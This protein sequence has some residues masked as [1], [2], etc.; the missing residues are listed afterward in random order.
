MH[1]HML[2]VLISRNKIHPK[3]NKT[4]AGD[5]NNGSDCARRNFRPMHVKAGTE[6]WDEKLSCLGP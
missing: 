2:I 3:A 6:L 5:Y 1:L 4:V